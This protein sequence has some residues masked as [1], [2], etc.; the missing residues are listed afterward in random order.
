M[1]IQKMMKQA[2]EM[3]QKIAD[4]QAKLE[5]EE[6]EGSSGGGMVVVRLNGKGIMKKI[7]IDAKIIDPSEKEMLEDLIVAA[8]NDAKGK[9]EKTTN[10]EMSKIA[11]G[12]GL[13]SG[14]KL[15][16]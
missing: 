2:Q 7:A 4:M 10:D 6:S 3:Q 9:I 14:M 1:N 11:G 16:F 15:P 8:F 13:P 5:E 12:L